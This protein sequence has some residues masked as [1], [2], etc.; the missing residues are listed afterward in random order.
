MVDDSFMSGDAAP[1][2]QI[3]DFQAPGT[4]ERKRKGFDFDLETDRSTSARV[5][6]HLEEQRIE[7]VNSR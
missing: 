7:Q 4:A 6:I 1:G 3:P 5:D 2:D